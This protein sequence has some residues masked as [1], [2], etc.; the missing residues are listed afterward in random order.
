MM[1]GNKETAPSMMSGLAIGP[2]HDR[3]PCR[4]WWPC[5]S[6]GETEKLAIFGPRRGRRGAQL[7]VMAAVETK[8]GVLDCL[9]MPLHLPIVASNPPSS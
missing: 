1:H 4:L 3:C 8:V 7:K 5:I 9:F 6:Q 2:C